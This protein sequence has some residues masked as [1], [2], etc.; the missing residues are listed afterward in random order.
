MTKYISKTEPSH[1]FNIKEN[2]RYY[3]HVLGRRL[4]AMET[5]FLLTGE[6]ICNSSATV[7]FLQ[8]DPPNIRSKTI[9]PVEN[10]L[11]N[12]EN[13]YYVDAVEKYFRRPYGQEFN[14]I[15]Y[16][17]YH[18]LYEIRNPNGSS[19]NRATRDLD[20]RIIVK[21]KKPILT[22]TRFTKLNDGE[23]Y[24]YYKLLQ[25]GSW[26]S[27]EELLG[28]F[29]Y[30]RDRYFSMFPN[31]LQTIRE[32]TRSYISR[33]T[34]Q[35]EHQFTSIVDSHLQSLQQEIHLTNIDIIQCQLNALKRLPHITPCIAG[36]NLPQDQY[37]AITVLTNM[38]GSRSNQWPYYFLTGSA[39]TG[40]SFIIHHFRTHL[41]QTKKKYIV[42]APT[43]V[44][45]QN[46]NG[47]TIH[48][49][50]KISSTTTN[51]QSSYRTLIFN[52]T[53]LLNEMRHIQTIIIDEVSMVSAS[54]FTFI[55]DTFAR[56]HNNHRPFGGIN[57]V[58]AGDLCQ[59]PPVQGTAVFHSPIWQLFYPLFLRNSQR[60]LNDNQYFN[61]LEEVRLGNIS[62]TSWQM[63]QT[64]HSQY[65]NTL[66]STNAFITT[67][68]VG[69][70]QSAEHLNVS[71]CNLLHVTCEDEI[72][73]STAIDKVN[74]EI[75]SNEHSQ[76]IFKQ[77]TNLPVDV[78]FQPGARVM[79]LSNDMINQGIC[80]GTIG[81]VTKVIRQNE[82]VHVSFLNNQSLVHAVIAPKT[83]YFS[84]NGANASR[85]QF[86][87]Q[88]CF[89]LTV[90]KSQGL[91]L[92][93]I[94]LYLDKQF[95]AAGQAYTA[96]SRAPS[97]DVVEIPYLDKQAF[98]VD[99]DV[100]REYE[101]LKNKASTNPLISYHNQLTFQAD[102]FFT[103]H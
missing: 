52:D 30:Y 20:G 29:T 5:I 81:I 98:T 24:Y 65:S 95:F 28:P 17:E 33:L 63:L 69:Y 70:K 74:G 92:P 54:L 80:N 22:R 45:A 89:A 26:R 44:A 1:V 40:K 50:L 78:R 87:L 49:A 18:Q 4:G 93:H 31:E 53:S 90:H 79:Y 36:T 7:N 82:Q 19:P 100:I 11:Q 85:R 88:N 77:H 42:L 67:S 46:V 91:T 66:T 41:Q 2:N 43:G 32:E 39:G 62:D 10:L 8:T 38:I 3:R 34:T 55:S 51:S 58:V 94:S 60:Q 101:R 73:I 99:Q 21:R 84:I 6:F 102:S 35:L 64:K 12:P 23:T 16:E 9:L 15:K 72:L 61:L 47:M 27:E 59:L 68:I 57:V 13:P 86:P 97:W 83:S 71:L 14:N 25:T 56:I 76:R 75:W 103:L 37:N 96:L 48:S